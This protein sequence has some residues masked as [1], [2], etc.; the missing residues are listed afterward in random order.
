MP[1]KA[2]R[3]ARRRTGTDKA[4][5]SPYEAQQV[6]RIQVRKA[7]NAAHIKT[8]TKLGTLNVNGLTKNKCVV[9]LEAFLR[10]GLDVLSL[11]DTRHS[12]ATASFWRRTLTEPLGPAT[13]VISNP[14]SYTS[15]AMGKRELVGGTIII[16]GK[17]WSGNI[18]DIWKDP[19]GCGVVTSATLIGPTRSLS[20]IATYWPSKP[21]TTTQNG[22]WDKLQRSFKH[23]DSHQSPIDYV[24]KR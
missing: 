7:S 11:V 18:Q 8:S 10:N 23:T 4:P 21:L 20:I 6:R 1:I 13:R 9:I 15:E 16:V 12:E 3:Q 17:R 5:K 19:S 24:K 22:L 2:R 14:A